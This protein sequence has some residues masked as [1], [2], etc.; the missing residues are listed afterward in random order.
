MMV[1][2]RIVVWVVSNCP[3]TNRNN[4]TVIYVRPDD[5]RRVI[6]ER[7]ENEMNRINRTTNPCR[8]EVWNERTDNR[9]ERDRVDLDIRIKDPSRW[10][11]DKIIREV[12][13]RVRV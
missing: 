9:E 4:E 7:I 12:T 3:I 10:I 8:V 6:E 13:N 5:E 2:E 11:K 1:E